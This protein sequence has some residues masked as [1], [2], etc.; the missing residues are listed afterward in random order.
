MT[1]WAYMLHCRG[2]SFYV[3][4]TDNLEHRIGQHQS[5]LI[6]GFTA[7]HLPVTLIWSQEFPSRH[8]AKDA[9]KRIKG[10]SRAKKMALIR[11]DWDRISVLAKSK[12]S[13]STG[14]GQA[15]KGDDED[16]KTTSAGDLD[17]H[18]QTARPELVEGLFLSLLCHPN[19]P[20]LA[21]RQI[22]VEVF[23]NEPDWVEMKFR[24]RGAIDQIA[25]PM[26]KSSERAD[27]LWEAT[28]F[29][30]FSRNSK[31]ESYEEL[32][33]SPSL[34]WAAYEF[35]SY[36]TG[37]RAIDALEPE[38]AVER[39]PSLLRLTARAA[40]AEGAGP[41]C[42]ALSAVIEETDGTKSYW[43]LAHPPGKPDFHHPDCFA[44]TLPAPD[45][46]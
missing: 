3:G 9:E 42:V 10:W 34:K 46:A 23:F 17:L 44:L 32:N 16:W 39:G 28:C 29:E 5:G 30:M 14:S 18:P 15:G 45:A 4:Q 1:F 21:V 33:F 13:P 38:I 12:N 43:A 6:A 22:L 35:D 2:G 24:V 27:R 7:E 8:E 20:S 26:T 36:R 19:T 11:G 37:M 40:L 25:V 41:W 31:Y